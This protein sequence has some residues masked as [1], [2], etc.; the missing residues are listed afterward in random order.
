MQPV[1]AAVPGQGRT[2]AA[3]VERV[4]ERPPAEP[5][6]RFQERDREAASARGLGRGQTGDA[7]TDDGEV[8]FERWIGWLGDG[9][10]S[11]DKGARWAGSA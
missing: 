10:T 4:G 7:G 5:G 6:L 1:T 3:R 9:R 2:A 11:A 8:D